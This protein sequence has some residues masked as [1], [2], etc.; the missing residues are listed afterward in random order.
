MGLVRPERDEFKSIPAPCVSDARALVGP[1]R[2]CRA[3]AEWARLFGDKSIPPVELP[4]ADMAGDVAGI[5]VGVIILATEFFKADSV[6]TK[7]QDI[8]Q[9]VLSGIRISEFGME[10]LKLT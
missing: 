5:D 6:S 4:L 2:P 3:M 1:L 7:R 8:N 10:N 9:D